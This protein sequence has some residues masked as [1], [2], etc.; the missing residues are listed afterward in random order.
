MTKSNIIQEFQQQGSQDLSLENTRRDQ[1]CIEG[2]HRLNKGFNV[3][4]LSEP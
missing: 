1:C 4:R 3:V 2:G